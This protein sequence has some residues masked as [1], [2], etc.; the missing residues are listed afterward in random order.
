MQLAE[1]VTSGV[2]PDGSELWEMPS[3][4]FTQLARE[5]MAA[6]IAYIRTVPPA[7][8]NH[9]LP[10][11]EEAARKEISAG[12]FRSSASEVQDEGNRLPPDVGAHHQLARYIVRATCADY[13]GMNL[14]GGQPHP[15]ATPRPDLRIAAVYE[16]VQFER[17]I[18][19]GIAAGDHEVSLM[20]ELARGRYKHLTETEIAAIYAYLQAVGVQ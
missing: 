7:A 6:L 1:I 14:E 9:P 20:S 3:H 16:K 19:T 11:F 10:R 13:H 15:T 17:L 5:D 2:R 4:L 18:K 8:P 12:T